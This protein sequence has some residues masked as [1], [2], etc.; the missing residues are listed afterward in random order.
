MPP[1]PSL[2]QESCERKLAPLQ[3]AEVAGPAWVWPLSSSW[4]LPGWSSITWGQRTPILR[5]IS[6][7]FSSLPGAAPCGMI[8]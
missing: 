3:P 8:S 5:H 4:G 6:G 7:Q 1:S 2:S